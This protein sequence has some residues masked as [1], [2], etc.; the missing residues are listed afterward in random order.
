MTPAP[1][2]LSRDAGASCPR[3]PPR[4]SHLLSSV[5]ADK[6]SRKMRA[7]HYHSD[8]NV[9]GVVVWPVVQAHMVQFGTR[10]NKAAAARM[11]RKHGCD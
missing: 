1:M 8:S 3:S 10:T 4:S 6:L 2:I 7:C 5:E 9:S 11:E